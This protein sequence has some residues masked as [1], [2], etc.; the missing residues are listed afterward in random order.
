MPSGA[1]SPEHMFVRVSRLQQP[2]VELLLCQRAMAFYVPK[3]AATL[4]CA[5]PDYGHAARLDLQ[6]Q[7]NPTAFDRRTNIKKFGKTQHC[8]LAGVAH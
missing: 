1:F 7:G 4:R 6:G 3:L 2:I 5:G 8:K